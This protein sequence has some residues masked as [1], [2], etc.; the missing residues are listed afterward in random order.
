MKKLKTQLSLAGFDAT[1]S[2]NDR[3]TV[4]K[5]WI[6][7]GGS[8]LQEAK[9]ASMPAQKL[10]IKLEIDTR[11]PA[12]AKTQRTMVTR[13]VLLAIQHYTPNSL[14]AGKVHALLT[15]K[16]PKGRDWYDLVWYRGHR[17]PQEPNLTLL[18]NALDQTQG[19]GVVTAGQW[20][21]LL[22]KKLS[23]L[24]PV[25]LMADVQPFLEH[26]DDARLLSAENLRAV[27]AE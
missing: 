11:P 12:G 9:L 19:Q 18:Q 24:D 5:A 17:P 22:L 27:L 23:H 8:L 7:V 6:K 4:H 10:S 26:P 25:R 2:W 14:M 1:V 21:E 20:R 3:T 15:R 13:H 16:Y